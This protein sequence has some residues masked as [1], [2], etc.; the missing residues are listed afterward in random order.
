MLL[1]S[2][3]VER[4]VNL[5]RHGFNIQPALKK[6]PHVCRGTPGVAQ[7]GVILHTAHQDVTLLGKPGIHLIQVSL[8]ARDQRRF[9]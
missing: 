8:Q 2:L 6:V 4:R 9:R 1:S 7:N 5:P 3:T